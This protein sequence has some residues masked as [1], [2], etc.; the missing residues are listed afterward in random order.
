MSNLV[1]EAA[2]V[3]LFVFTGRAVDANG[4]SAEIFCR[5]G[6]HYPERELSAIRVRTSLCFSTHQQSCTERDFSGE[7]GDAP[8]NTEEEIGCEQGGGKGV[9]QSPERKRAENPNE[10]HS[11]N[12]DR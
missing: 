10:T 6:P 5:R 8:R 1:V 2:P 7:D 3:K 9:R 4:D 12:D 11:E